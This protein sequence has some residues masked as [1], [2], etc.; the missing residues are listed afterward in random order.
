LRH[1]CHSC[2]GR[3]INGRD[4]SQSPH[5]LKD[6]AID[7]VRRAV[8]T[9]LANGE[10]TALAAKAATNTIPVVFIGGSDPVRLGLVAR[11]S[12]P[13]GNI[14]G[15][16]VLNV[17]VASKRLQLLKELVP[18]AKEIA[19]LFD[20]ASPSSAAQ[21]KELLEAESALGLEIEIL[22]A[23]S[24]REIDMAFEGFVQRRMDAILIGSSARFNAHSERLGTLSVRYMV[25]G[26]LSNARVCHRRWIRELRRQYS[27]RIPSRWRL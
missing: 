27:R 23:N 12:R 24:I 18:S 9:I 26:N 22:H 8:S 21:S 1:A 7:L 20:P 17:D 16:T 2:L 11:L 5:R 19:V 15:A 25:P 6:L 4:D 3:Q 10:P 14:T 13:G